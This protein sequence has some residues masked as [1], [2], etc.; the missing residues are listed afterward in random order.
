MRNTWTCSLSDLDVKVHLKGIQV[1]ITMSDSNNNSTVICV[2]RALC[3][4]KHLFLHW[5]VAVI[6]IWCTVVRLIALK[7][8]PPSKKPW[9]IWKTLIPQNSSKSTSNRT[10][11]GIKLCTAIYQEIRVLVSFSAGYP[12]TGSTLPVE[13]VMYT[14]SQAQWV[15]R[16]VE[17]LGHCG[18]RKDKCMSCKR[19]STYYLISL[20]AIM[21]TIIELLTT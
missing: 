18:K 2:L 11:F 3:V 1:Q 15:T 12:S 8:A 17:I 14:L 16:N 10:K 6:L 9:W 19:T 20:Q 7:N 21:R 5:T 13:T 4:S